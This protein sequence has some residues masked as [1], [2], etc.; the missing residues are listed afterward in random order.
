MTLVIEK[1]NSTWFILVHVL[2]VYKLLHVGLHYGSPLPEKSCS[3]KVV[4]KLKEIERA[5]K[6][7]FYPPAT[8]P[9]ARLF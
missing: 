7:D 9:I 5:R 1:S 8:L 3:I 6:K 4:R 2:K